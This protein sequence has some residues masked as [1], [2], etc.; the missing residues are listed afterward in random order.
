MGNM[1]Y[2]RVQTIQFQ[3][4]KYTNHCN[5]MSK[6]RKKKQRQLIALSFPNPIP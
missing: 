3:F 4:F 5:R 6:L 1:N 2:R